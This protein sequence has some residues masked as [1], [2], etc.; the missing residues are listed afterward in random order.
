MAAEECVKKTKVCCF[1]EN[2]ESG[3]IES[4]LCNVLTR[5][6]RTELA[7]DIVTASMGKSIFTKPLQKCGIHFFELS[8]N[9][10]KVV[11]NHCRFRKLL[12]ER[13]YDAIYVNAFHGL[14]LAYLRIAKQEGVPLRIAHSHNTALRKSLT[15]PI[16]LTIHTW[17]KKQFTQYA[18]DLWACSKSAAKFLFSERILENKGFRFIP[19]GIDIRRFYFDPVVRKSVRTDLGLED[20]FVIGNVGR[21]CYQKNQTFL[22]K[23]FSEVLRKNPDSRL[24]LVG[25]G[26]KLPALRK[27]AKRLGIEEKVIFYGSSNHIEQLFCS[28]DVFAFPSKFEG[29]GIVTIEA[30]A[31]GLP[32]VASEFIPE[33]AQVTDQFRIVPLEQGALEWALV[34]LE[35]RYSDV[36][37]INEVVAIRKA[38]FDVTDVSRQIKETYVR[39]NCNGQSKD[40]GDRSSL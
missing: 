25:E 5:M 38:G 35:Q 8:G 39:L 20:K 40:F 19:N 22:L 1:C 26:K 4:F 7:V 31:S 11:E 17:A 24:L 15:R 10:R 32:V 16:K 13:H 9:Q 21:L 28:M 6:E 27:K 30:Q 23:V 37:R 12:R 3:G 34:L 36:E 2:W 33:E 29:L 14:S 18:T